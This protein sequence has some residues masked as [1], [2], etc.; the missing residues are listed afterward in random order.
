MNSS[1]QFIAVAED[2]SAP[3]VTTT[4]CGTT[5]AGNINSWFDLGSGSGSM[6]VYFQGEIVNP[7][8]PQP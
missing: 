3:A 5:L 7:A 8:V 6:A 4:A 1:G 2:F